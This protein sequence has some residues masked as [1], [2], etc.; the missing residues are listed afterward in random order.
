MSGGGVVAR[1]GERDEADYGKA[2]KP[3]GHLCRAGVKF[4]SDCADLPYVLRFYFAWK[5]GLPFG[6]VS[7]VEPRGPTRDFRYT[8]T[9]NEAASRA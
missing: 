5:R 1:A 3:A 6:Y 2:E 8:A 9:G 4:R 7:A